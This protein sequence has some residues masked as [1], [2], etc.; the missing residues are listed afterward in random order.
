[1][2]CQKFESVASELARGQMMEADVRG[3]ALA[4]VDA[5]EECALRL[6]DEETLTRG[7]RSLSG[8]MAALNAPPELELKL[9]EAFRSRAVVVRRSH[10]NYWV[11]GIAAV[12]LIAASVIAPS[13]NTDKSIEV[14]ADRA[15][16]TPIK[17]EPRVDR[18]EPPKKQEEVAQKPR[19]R[20]SRRA[21]GTEVANHVTREIA[22]DFMPLGYLNPATLQ[23]GGQIVRVELPRSAL[24]NFGLPVNMER[25]HETVKADVLLGVDGLAHAIRFVQ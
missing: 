5:C 16:P 1:M 14:I 20:V 21:P 24:V 22:T 6:R 3:E 17:E 2:N 8:E 19:K 7:L 4:H 18:P 15:E 10:V 13:W 23:D 11:A 25:Y 9:R 12:L